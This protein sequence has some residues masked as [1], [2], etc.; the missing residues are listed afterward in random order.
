MQISRSNI[1]TDSTE[2]EHPLVKKTKDCK[3][4]LEE[5]GLSYREEGFYLEVGEPISKGWVLHVSAIRIQ[6]TPMLKAVLPVLIDSKVAFKIPKDKDTAKNL[7]DGT[8]GYIQLG[9]L[10]CIYPENDAIAFALAKDLIKI[11][12]EFRS[13]SIPTDKLLGA[14]VYTIYEDRESLN[15]TIPFKLPK[16]IIW[17]FDKITSLI[18][19]GKKSLLNYRYRPLS[20]IKS[21]VKGRVIQG[22]YFKS[23]FNI[24]LCIIKEGIKNMWA[25]ELGRD[26]VDRINWQYDL[27]KELGNRIPT[28][29]IFDL[30]QENNNT[31][32]A[33]EFI[34]GNSLHYKIDSLYKRDSAHQLSINY[35]LSIVEIFIK[36]LSVIEVLHDNGYVHRD[37]TPEN[38]IITKKNE[39]FLIDM[40]LTYCIPRQ[41]PNPVFK[42]GTNGYMSSEQQNSEIP[43][44]KEDIY[45]L[46]CLLFFCFTGL[47]PVKLDTENSEYLLSNL[48]FLTG[49]KSL[50]LLIKDCISKIPDDRPSTAIIRQKIEKY[51]KEIQYAK[52]RTNHSLDT[53]INNSKTTEIINKALS[54]LNSSRILTKG[55]VWESQNSTNDV[56]GT[57]STDRAPSIGFYSG[58]T[59]ILYTVA[60]A[61][62][63]GYMIDNCLPAYNASWNYIQTIYPDPTATIPPGLYDGLAGIA[64]ALN[65]GLKSNLLTESFG[66]KHLQSLFIPVSSEIDL[67]RGIAGQGISLI[68]CMSNLSPEFCQPVFRQYLD[69]LLYAQRKD[70]SWHIYRNSGKGKD[71]M[72]GLAHGTAGILLFLLRYYQNFREI[73]LAAPIEKGMRWLTENLQNKIGRYYWTTSTKSKTDNSFDSSLG[74]PGVALLFIK[75]YEILYNREYK[76]IAEKVLNSMPIQPINSDYTQAYGLSGLGELYLEAYHVFQKEDWHERSSWIANLFMHTFLEDKEGRGH[77]SVNIYPDLEGDLMTGVS[78]IIH[79]LMRYQMQDK[80]GYIY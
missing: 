70:G 60:V 73:S 2:I 50:S 20:I 21:D 19:P 29:Q 78:G 47:P 59:G 36:I 76:A 66:K 40:E 54:G 8:L 63:L 52:D 48:E 45:A 5:Y 75:A 10:I 30:F 44:V 74:T 49:N 61:K 64:L 38:F 1:I 11:T 13:P 72:I 26:I 17:P 32:L 31:Y 46:G 77:W 15:Y 7:L 24:K 16:S 51:K 3:E 4:I 27:Y 12:H 53:K 35:K 28:P 42:L 69:T 71:N 33:M 57:R 62:K 14:T 25:D 37:I 34:K 56:V 80:L 18:E 79:F 6:F 22:N 67:A 39:V 23:L 58:M 41:Y 55:K 65:E 68:G 9:K 43:T